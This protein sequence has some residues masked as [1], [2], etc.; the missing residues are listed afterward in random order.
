[1]EDPLLPRLLRQRKSRLSPTMRATLGALILGALPPPVVPE[2][3]MSAVELAKRRSKLSL[4]ARHALDCLREEIHSLPASLAAR[5]KNAKESREFLLGTRGKDNNI[6]V[7]PAANVGFL[8]VYKS[9]GT[10]TRKIFGNICRELFKRDNNLR[11]DKTI[12]GNETELRLFTFVRNKYTRFASALYEVAASRKVYVF[13]HFREQFANLSLPERMKRVLSMVQGRD[14][15]AMNRHFELQAS[16]LMKDGYP[17][18]NLAM[19]GTLENFVT[20]M[21]VMMKTL[22]DIHEDKDAWLIETLQHREVGHSKNDVAVHD[23]QTFLVRAKELPQFV[24]DNISKLY[25]LDTKCGL[26]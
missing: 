2:F 20:D 10:T 19:I 22:L 12:R 3:N 13:W 16:F 5:S 4:R 11:E 17:L 25:A 1:M 23:A 6:Y 18:Y 15:Q 24:Q 21:Y 26:G 14:G 8:H 7:C 9:G